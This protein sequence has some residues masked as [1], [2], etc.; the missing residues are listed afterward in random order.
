ME[1][2][3]QRGSSGTAVPCFFCDQGAGKDAAAGALDRTGRNR[4]NA[5]R[6]TVRRKCGDGKWKRL[7]RVR[8]RGVQSWSGTRLFRTSL[9]GYQRRRPVLY[10][11]GDDYRGVP[12]ILGSWSSRPVYRRLCVRGAGDAAA[13]RAGQYQRGKTDRLAYRKIWFYRRQI[14]L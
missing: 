12:R 10:R 1:E 4:E 9:C 11:R 5:E 8:H 14:S 7:P 13:D 3:R 6:S 2:R